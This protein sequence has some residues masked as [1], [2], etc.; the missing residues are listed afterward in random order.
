MHCQLTGDTVNA[1]DNIEL[2][3]CALEFVPQQTEYSTW[4][5][6]SILSAIS[7]ATKLHKQFQKVEK[8]LLFITYF[9]IS[10][11]WF[12]W[13]TWKTDTFGQLLQNTTW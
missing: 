7:P 8:L 10:S 1:S 12:S 13:N 4:G 6:L 5:V 2:G 11:C 3:F 9:V